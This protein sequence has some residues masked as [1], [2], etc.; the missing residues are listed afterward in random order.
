M[1]E[2]I[3]KLNTVV[4]TVEKNKNLTNIQADRLE[5]YMRKENIIIAGLKEGEDEG[6]AELEADLG[7]LFDDMGVEV[8][9]ADISTYHRLG[10]KTGQKTRPVI[11]RFVK[12]RTKEAIMGKRKN[13]KEKHPGIYVNE[14]MTPARHRLFNMVR[15]LP[16]VERVNVK[17]GIIHVNTKTGRHVKIENAEDLFELGVDEIDYDTIYNQK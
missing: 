1:G 2:I 4:L 3:T 16:T 17:D 7:K 13:L 11:V 10:R 8:V 14:D 6:A 15:R 5:Q 12:R 9:G